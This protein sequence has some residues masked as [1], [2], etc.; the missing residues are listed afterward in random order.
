MEFWPHGIFSP[1]RNGLDG[2]VI[3]S[4]SFKPV[5]DRKKKR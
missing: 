1:S 5:Y 3:G 4:L 2:G